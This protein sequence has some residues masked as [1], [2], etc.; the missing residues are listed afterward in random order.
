MRSLRMHHRGSLVRSPMLSGLRYYGGKSAN[1]P[2]GTGRWIAQ[3]LP[4][5]G[6]TTYCEPFA[7]MLGVLLQR[8]P[9]DREI[10]SDTNERVINWWRVVR[11]MPD[12]FE[13]LVQHT[14]HSRSEFEWAKANLDEGSD[15]S[16][17]LAFHIVVNQS[18]LNSDAR[19]AFWVVVRLP[20]A[21]KSVWPKGRIHAI[22]RRLQNVRIDCR[23]ALDTLREVRHCEDTLAY[24]DPPYQGA[25]TSGYRVGI[26]GVDLDSL[27][28]ELRA[29]RGRIA[30]SGYGE[31]W[32]NLGWYRHERETFTQAAAAAKTKRPRVEV[33]WTN[34]T[35]QSRFI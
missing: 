23:D 8:V 15:L 11:D 5:E 1:S 9:S 14:P 24:I 3:I 22:S 27:G 4:T 6:V 31:T 10:V 30:I 35:L 29:Q 13:N 26:D 28:A 7:G 33:L 17:A 16:R 19:N 20:A 34:Y 32:D 18:A 12:A 21:A 25:D 2:T